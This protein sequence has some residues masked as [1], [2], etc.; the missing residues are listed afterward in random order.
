MGKAFSVEDECRIVIDY[1]V[2]GSV[3]GVC[4]I[5]GDAVGVIGVPVDVGEIYRREFA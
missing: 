4:C 3:A 2:V 5:G 1:A